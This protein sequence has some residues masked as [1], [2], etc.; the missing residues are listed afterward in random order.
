MSSYGPFLLRESTFLI[1]LITL[2]SL[3]FVSVNKM[4]SGLLDSK[5]F[6]LLLVVLKDFSD[7][8]KDWTF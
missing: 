3:N 2:L 4:I 8:L 1:L 6:S 5:I 7:W